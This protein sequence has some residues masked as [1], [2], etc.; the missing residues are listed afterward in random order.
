[1]FFSKRATWIFEIKFLEANSSSGSICSSHRE[2]IKDKDRI[3]EIPHIFWG[4]RWDSQVN[5]RNY[6]LLPHLMQM[7]EG[8]QLYLAGSWALSRSQS[9]SLTDYSG[10]LRL[11]GVP[12]NLWKWNFYC[13]GM[14]LDVQYLLTKSSNFPPF[15]CE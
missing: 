12:V 6:S 7:R 4:L 5:I 8:S 14:D 13:T 9:S 1:M 10:S 15:P 11:L 3:K 2:S